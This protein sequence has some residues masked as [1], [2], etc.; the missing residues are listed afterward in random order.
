M[1]LCTYLYYLRQ[2]IRLYTIASNRKTID[3]EMYRSF[4]EKLIIPDEVTYWNKKCTFETEG[5]FKGSIVLR[6]PCH[7]REFEQDVIRG[8]IVK[9][10]NDY[11]LIPL[12][13]YFMTNNSYLLKGM[14]RVLKECHFPELGDLYE[15]CGSTIAKYCEQMSPLICENLREQFNSYAFA[16]ILIMESGKYGT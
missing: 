9:F 12:S 3:D 10:E 11:M 14:G 16:A 7:N 5:D 4:L 1:E 6:V 2:L 15:N 8:N 13:H